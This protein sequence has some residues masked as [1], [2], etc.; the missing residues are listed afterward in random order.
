V[1]PTDLARE[2]VG[3]A[4]RQLDRMSFL[5][6][7]L[8]AIAQLDSGHA[9][10]PTAVSFGLF[11]DDI[12]GNW[13][14]SADRDWAIDCSESAIIAAD[15]EWLGLAVDAI[16]ENAVN[17][18]EPGGRIS[19]RSSVSRTACMISISDSGQGIDP[20]D[21]HH[22]FERFWH[23]RPPFGDMGSGL[24]LSM[25]L[26]TAQAHGGDVTAQNAPEGGAVFTLTLP[27]S[28]D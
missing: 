2:D 19:I 22:I 7:R 25:A 23:R 10:R 20:H 26:A 5:S 24:G 3:V 14:N 18:T 9:L 8:L 12:A 11:L 13:K 4:L 27:R 6:N 1:L 16:I 21:L 28:S 17:Y 15:I